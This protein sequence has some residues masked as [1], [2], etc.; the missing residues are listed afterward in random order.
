MRIRPLLL[1]I[2]VLNTNFI[3]S[4]SHKLDSV[5]VQINTAKDDR[6]KLPSLKLMSYYQSVIANLDSAIY[7]GEQ[8][9]EIA[10]KLNLKK[11][12]VDL[13]GNLGSV[14]SD[15]GKQPRALELFL[16]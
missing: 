8:G 5:R 3:R 10:T 2:F 11:D 7:F 9:V 12:L 4:Q 13:Y 16:K 14:Y 1:L 6:S 15:K